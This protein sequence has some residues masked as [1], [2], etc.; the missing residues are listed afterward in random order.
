M[1]P[2]NPKQQ[3]PLLTAPA[4]MPVLAAEV[5]AHGE[6]ILQRLS[7]R[8]E[9]N[10]NWI[11]FADYMQF[12]LY[13]PEL[14]YYSSGLQKFGV[15]GDFTTAPEV[16]PLFGECLAAS[17]ADLLRRHPEWSICELGPGRGALAES[18]LMHLHNLDALP[19]SYQLLEVSASLSDLQKKR[20]DKL[21]LDIPIIHL[22]TPPHNFKGIIIANE[23]IDAL[24]V[25]R[26][27]IDASGKV[28]QVGLSLDGQQ[29]IQTTK[30]APEY[31]RRAVESLNTK[32]PTHYSSELCLQLTPWLASVAANVDEAIFLFSDYGFSQGEYYSPE[33]DQG[34]LRC[35]YRHHAHN[36]YSVLP[37]LQDLTAWVNFTQL[38]EAALSLNMEVVAYTTQAHFLLG[39]GHLHTLDLESL[40][41][42]ERFKTS[43]DIQ[44][45]SLPANMGERFR[46][47]QLNKNCDDLI[48]AMTLRDL[49]HQL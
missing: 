3:H 20:L 24:P 1:R 13:E 21:K 26:F 38:G 12:C 17:I 48:P 15:D 28:H 47:M 6:R 33:R 44:T 18:L 11:S 8:L 10:D 40:T 23:V 4:G 27:Y 42:Q 9:D 31:L 7:R 37:G 22:D 14:G 16:S 2:V 35:H 5:Y 29:L 39:S 49:R 41:E 36:D 32:L 19:A 46:F 43:K 25:E 45:L 30:P 34:T